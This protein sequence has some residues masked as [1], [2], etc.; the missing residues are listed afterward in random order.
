MQE[1]ELISK[2]LQND[3][4][5]VQYFYRLYQQRL[6]R[7]VMNK[8][9]DEQDGEEITHDILIDALDSLPFF[10]GDS[11]LFSW[12]CGIARHNIADFYRRQKIK[13]IVFSVFPF[14]KKLT[15]EALSPEFA[16][17]KEELQNKFYATLQGLPEGFSQIL[18]LKYIDGLTLAEIAEKLDITY[19]AAESKL[20]RARLAFQKEFVQN[21]TDCQKADQ[22]FASFGPA[23][24]VSY[25][26]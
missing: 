24:R 16:L 13:S 11:S 3:Q 19:K 2:L 9:Q 5:A 15:D 1:K 12:L 14:L 10:K 20:F 26:P 17:E 21:N 22:V 25:R 18:R 8:I 6:L 4:R 23:R 7:F